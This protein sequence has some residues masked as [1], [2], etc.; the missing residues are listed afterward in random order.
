MTQEL[1]ERVE[2]L[3]TV[4]AEPQR[5]S[6][7]AI[8][9]QAA[10]DPNVDVAKMQSLL[11]MQRQIMAEQARAEFN[12]AF[13]RLNLPRIPKLG[14]VDRGQGKGKFPYA[15]WEDIDAKI[16]PL[17]S[18]EGF[19]LSFDTKPCGDHTIVVIG[20]LRHRSGHC[21]TASIGPLALDTSGNKN[22]VQAV[23]STTSYGKRYTASMLLNLAFGGDD[24]DGQA[25][26]RPAHPLFITDEQI[27]EING[28]IRETESDSRKVLAFADGA[29]SVPEMTSSQYAKARAM[30]LLK[31]N[32]MAREAQQ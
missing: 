18:A 9:A 21:E 7:L 28:L 2:T 25:A 32:R 30:L 12:E 26:I 24:D 6:M 22:P 16:R 23:G 10:S 31:K 8:I 4:E 11:D 13:A 19:A 5:R 29:P 1:V 15:R 17:L 20:T 14:I 27:A 3:P